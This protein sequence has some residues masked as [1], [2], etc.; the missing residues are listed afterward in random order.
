MAERVPPGRAGRLWLV[1]RLA[2]ARRSLELLDRKHQLLLRELA[3]RAQLRDET[4]RRWARA[5]T[6]AQ[7]WGA[8]ADALGGHSDITLAAASIS[9]QARVDVPW[10]NTMGVVHPGDPACALPDLPPLERAA[11]NVAIAPLAAAQREALLAAAVFAA[12]DRSHRLLEAELRKTQRRRR[13]VEHHRIP[14]LE[15]SLLRLELHL[16]EL[17]REERVVSRWVRSRYASVVDRADEG[18]AAT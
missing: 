13:A 7:R 4:E 16:D 11:G 1:R 3:G 10:H 2:F 17:E 6:E 15:E 5:C 12:L 18:R 8:R 9:G 14:S